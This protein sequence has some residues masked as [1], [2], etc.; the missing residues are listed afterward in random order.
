MIAKIKIIII[1]LLVS[2]CTQQMVRQDPRGLYQTSDVWRRRRLA[3]API[4]YEF[5]RGGDRDVKTEDSVRRELLTAARK[6]LSEE[7]GYEATPLQIYEDII[8]QKFNMFE[9]QFRE[10][11]DL[12]T[13]WAKSSGDGEQ[14]PERVA[15]AASKLGRPLNVDGLAGC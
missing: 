15:A 2:G 13:T 9:E 12:L 14:P 7:K 1:L 10:H 3:I 8:P 4:Q 6:I 5:S 11:L